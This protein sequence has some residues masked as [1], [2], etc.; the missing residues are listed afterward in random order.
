MKTERQ[1]VRKGFRC[2]EDTVEKFDHIVNAARETYSG[3]FTGT[4]SGTD[5][6]EAMVDFIYR[7]LDT[8]KMKISDIF[9]RKK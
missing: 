5:A 7:K 1:P 4:I 3:Q 6:F 9:E 8:K 2:N